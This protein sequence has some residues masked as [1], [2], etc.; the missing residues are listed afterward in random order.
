VV[1]HRKARLPVALGV[2]FVAGSAA[3]FAGP[4]LA[5]AASGL[6]GFAATAVVTQ[7]SQGPST[8]TRL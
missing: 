7:P 2:G 1:R 8:G 5:M 3:S 4:W 6:G